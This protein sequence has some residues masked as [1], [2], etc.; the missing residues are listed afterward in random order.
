MAAMPVGNIYAVDFDGTLC[1]SRYPDIGDPIPEVIDYCKQRK[2]AGDK[3]VLWTCRAGK[4]LDAA[5]EWC[6]QQGIEFDA[7]NANIQ[8][9]I[10]EYG[11]DSRKVSAD[12]YIDDRAVSVDD[13]RTGAEVRGLDKRKVRQY[14]YIAPELRAAAPAQADAPP[15]ISGYFAV[16]GSEYGMGMG[17]TESVDPTAF[18]ATLGNDV[19]ALWNHDTNI[20][21]GR[22]KAGTLKLRT[23]DHGLWGDITVNPADTDAMNAYARIARGDVGECSFGFDILREESQQR[24]DG[25]WHFRIIEVELYEVSPVAFPAY[26]E[27]SVS[28]RADEVKTLRSRQNQIWKADMKAR[29][30]RNA[31]TDRPA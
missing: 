29:L 11:G 24:P 13:I 22:T 17:I 7:V 3:L 26:K 19:R 30:E 1:E 21:L 31:Q 25:S 5:V 10:D 27:T 12:C 16:F 23:D 20:V 4:H 18:D 8:E 28:A 2:A 15:M 6:K 9:R 14:R